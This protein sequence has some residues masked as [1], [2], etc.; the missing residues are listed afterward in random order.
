MK[1]PLFATVKDNERVYDNSNCATYKGITL[2][3]VYFLVVALIGAVLAV[4]LLFEGEIETVFTIMGVSGFVGLIAF[5][6]GRTNPNAAKVCGTI[7]SLS[8]GF[9]LG[10]ISCI[11]EALGYEGST[12]IAVAAT[13][14]VFATMLGI[15]ASGIIRNKSTI[16]KVTMSIGLCT[17]CVLLMTLILS[18]CGFYFDNI[19]LVIGIELLVLVYGCCMLLVSFSDA[20]TLVQ[21]GFGKEYEWQCAFGLSFALLYI[22][23]EILRLVWIL[24]SL[25]NRD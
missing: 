21:E 1:N 4:A 13:F 25:F 20:T 11:G 12:L 3:T 24:Y 17:L 8:E 22:Y 5:L 9:F 16:Y 19:G 14:T 18:L 6:I 2:K 23:L 7:Y 10:A 15:F